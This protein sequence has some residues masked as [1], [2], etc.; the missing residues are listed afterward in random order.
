ML[1]TGDECG[2]VRFYDI[3]MREK[4]ASCKAVV[5]QLNQTDLRLDYDGGS[6]LVALAGSYLRIFDVRPK[7][8]GVASMPICLIGK[9]PAPLTSLVIHG[10]RLYNWDY[11]DDFLIYPLPTVLESGWRAK[12]ESELDKIALKPVFKLH[13]RHT[14]DVQVDGGRFYLLVQQ[15]HIGCGPHLSIH[16]YSTESFKCKKFPK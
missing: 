16:V 10:Q 12:S 5:P 1:A 8:I 7:C 3:S 2:F 6:R 13:I 14:V 11:F 9:C 15:Y 4:I